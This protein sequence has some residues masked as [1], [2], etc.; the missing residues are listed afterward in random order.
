MANLFIMHVEHQ[1]NVA[2]TTTA[3]G[4]HVRPTSRLSVGAVDGTLDG[5]LQI[6]VHG[7]ASEFALVDGA[8]GTSPATGPQVVYGFRS[9]AGFLSASFRAVNVSRK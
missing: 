3:L 4:M 7:F 8:D 1:S 9:V 6:W 2:S 5:A